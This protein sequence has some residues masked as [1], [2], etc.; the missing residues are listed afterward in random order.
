MKTTMIGIFD[1]LHENEKH[2]V[3]LIKNPRKKPKRVVGGEY[4]G[5]RSK[6]KVRSLIQIQGLG[7]YHTHN[8]YFVTE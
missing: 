6:L 4:R 2:K 1:K 3:I 5:A 8:M 7:I